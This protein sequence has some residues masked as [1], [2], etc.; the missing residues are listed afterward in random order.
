MRLF[1]DKD[2]M[3]F[4]ETYSSNFTS[5]FKLPERQSVERSHNNDLGEKS[6]QS[7]GAFVVG[8]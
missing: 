7:Y 8:I 4:V 1:K 6:L 3:Y 2:G 5:V